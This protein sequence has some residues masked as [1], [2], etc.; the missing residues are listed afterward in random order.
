MTT[1]LLASRHN[2]QQQQ[3][4]SPPIFVLTW[5]RIYLLSY[6]AFCALASLLQGLR[7]L[8]VCSD[9]SLLEGRVL[10]ATQ[11]YAEHLPLEGLL[12][13]LLFMG[14]GWRSWTCALL[15]GNA[16]A[17]VAAAV[18][19]GCSTVGLEQSTRLLLITGWR[20][21]LCVLYLLTWKRPGCRPK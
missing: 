9:T 14:E 8:V 21:G 19:F 16:F 18:S 5:Y 4:R 6:A 3:Q 17:A 10:Q 7:L 12:F 13:N 1:T 11:L 2:Q 20:L 15:G